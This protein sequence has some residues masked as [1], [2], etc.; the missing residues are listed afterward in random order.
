MRSRGAPREKR[1]VGPRFPSCVRAPAHTDAAAPRF[2]DAGQ[3]SPVERCV[4]GPAQVVSPVLS[5][6]E[7]RGAE[8]NLTR[9]W[10]DPG[11]T[12]DSAGMHRGLKLRGGTQELSELT[13]EASFGPTSFGT[14]NE[15][16]DSV[17]LPMVPLETNLSNPNDENGA[18]GSVE[19][20]PSRIRVRFWPNTAGYERMLVGSD[21]TFPLPYPKKSPSCLQ[22]CLP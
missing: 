8:S 14:K 10:N 3:D 1:G 9:S 20:A 18:G 21:T 4:P 2:W 15:V 22:H 16:F 19:G 17:G 11:A 6:F 13:S 12:R 5:F 7:K